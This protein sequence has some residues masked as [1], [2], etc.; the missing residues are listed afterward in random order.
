MTIIGTEVT[1]QGGVELSTEE[2]L[3]YIGYLRNKHPGERVT[4]LSI[5]ITANA[6]TGEET[7]TLDYA[8]EAPRFE[9]IRRITGYLVGDMGR[10]NNAKRAEEKDRVKHNI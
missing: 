8:T 4:K 10:W 6:S 1:V 7:V 5:M 9:R 3:A 2:I